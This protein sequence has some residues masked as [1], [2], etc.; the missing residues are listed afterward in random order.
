MH[1]AKEHGLKHRIVRF[2]QIT[3]YLGIGLMVAV[4]LVMAFGLLTAKGHV[5]W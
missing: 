2:E 1:A 4:G 3:E 5:T